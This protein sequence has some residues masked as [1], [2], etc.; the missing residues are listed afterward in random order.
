M[1]FSSKVSYM[2]KKINIS[3]NYDT[4]FYHVIKISIN[5]GAKLH[6]LFWFT[7]DTYE[8]GNQKTTISTRLVQ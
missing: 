8:V 3:Y 1:T 5:F 2:V 6:N 4:D 7:Y